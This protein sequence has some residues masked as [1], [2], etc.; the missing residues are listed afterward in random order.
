MQHEDQHERPALRPVIE[1]QL[2]PDRKTLS[3]RWPGAPVIESGTTVLAR[4]LHL[5][6]R[7]R[8]RA[9]GRMRNDPDK[10]IQAQERS[11]VLLKWRHM[12]AGDTSEFCLDR[13]LTVSTAIH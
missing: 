5:E 6:R 8:L 12:L 3:R 2:P 10:M 7:A 13:L 1:A 9:A 4:R 11:W